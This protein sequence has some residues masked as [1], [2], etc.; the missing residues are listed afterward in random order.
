MT[1]EK[2]AR[3]SLVQILTRT[4]V[5]PLVGRADVRV[6]LP[7]AAGDDS[8]PE[9]DLAV[10]SPAR[11]GEPHPGRAFL[12]I[13]V[14]ETS[15]E[16]DRVEK[17]ELYARVG[18]PEYWVVNVPDQSIE[19]HTGLREVLTHALPL[20]SRRSRRARR[21]PRGKRRRGAALRGLRIRRR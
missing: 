9:P 1:P 17:A 6:R 3:A 11:F 14:A 7:F 5:P 10:V 4:L 18:V 16:Y 12:I 21:V 15:L 20:P 19:V 2:E 13:E 8:M